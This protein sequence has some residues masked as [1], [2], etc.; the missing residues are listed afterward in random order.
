MKS[1]PKFHNSHHI[2]T[3]LQ[4]TEHLLAHFCSQYTRKTKIFFYIFD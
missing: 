4:Q 2:T 3:H 1:T